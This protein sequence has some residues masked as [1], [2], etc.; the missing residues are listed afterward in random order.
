[1]SENKS[2]D[3]RSLFDSY[4][5]PCTL[6]G[7]GEKLLVRP[8][9]T[10][11]MKKIL[12]YEDET[13]VGIVEEALDKLITECVVTEGFNINKLYL[14]DRF[15]LLLEIRK[16]S[17]GSTYNFNFKCPECKLDNIKS[18]SLDDLNVKK[19]QEEIDNI[20]KI[21][22]KFSLVIDFPT[23]EDQKAAFNYVKRKKLK[24]RQREI[25]MATTLY[26]CCV[27]KVI[28]T[29]GDVNNIPLDDKIY[30]LD[31][32]MSSQFDEFK[33]WFEKNEFGVDFDVEVSCINCDFTAKQSIPL[34]DFFG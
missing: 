15:Y 4:E 16:I 32:L 25:E 11:Q 22:S 21:N 18:F 26:A 27:K 24:G 30:I 23:R 8:I 7:S 13:D 1:M 17:K 31:N 6:P 19:K 10:G 29:D 9:T 5:F 2:V 14:Q 3:V 12:I 33:E 28:S 34:T 20:I